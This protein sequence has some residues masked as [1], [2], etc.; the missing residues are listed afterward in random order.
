MCAPTIKHVQM[1]YKWCAES[2]HP[3]VYIYDEI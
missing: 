3:T 1:V 2:S